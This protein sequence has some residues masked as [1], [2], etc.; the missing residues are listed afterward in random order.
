MGL[1]GHMSFILVAYVQEEKGGREVLQKRIKSGCAI[2]TGSTPLSP[3]P[4]PQFLL[5]QAS[6]L[7]HSLMPPTLIANSSDVLDSVFSAGKRML[8]TK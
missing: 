3:S 7:A 5:A 6:Q 2:A 8:H 1:L 4:C